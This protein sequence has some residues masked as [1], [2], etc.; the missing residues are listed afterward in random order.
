MTEKLAS[1]S[2]VWNKY[3]S[4]IRILMKKSLSGE[5]VLGMNR[6]DFDRAAGIRKSGYRF[7]INFVN[8]KP[9]AL[10]SGNGFVQ[11]FIA[12]LRS[13]ETIQELLSN[14]NYA[15]VFTTKYQLQI[16]NNGLLEQ[17]AEPAAETEVLSH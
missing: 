7:I 10:F 12:A 8:N 3:L 13:D 9:D 16:K 1:Y 4:A 17:T 15:F 11:S 5:Q 6:N 2:P 14:N